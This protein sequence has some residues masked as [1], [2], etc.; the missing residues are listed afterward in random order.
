MNRK[1]QIIEV[2]YPNKSFRLITSPT[3]KSINHLVIL[4]KKSS[5]ESIPKELIRYRIKPDK[6]YK[7]SLKAKLL[8]ETQLHSFSTPP[9]DQLQVKG[10]KFL[11]SPPPVSQKHL[12]LKGYLHVSHSFKTPVQSNRGSMNRKTCLCTTFRIFN[13]SRKVWWLFSSKVQ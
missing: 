11:G 2:D 6:T 9:P 12:N 10:N 5:N 1:I 4:P 3:I 7:N 13:C 8:L